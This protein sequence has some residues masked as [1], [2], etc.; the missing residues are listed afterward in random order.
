M[1]RPRT[2]RHE[3]IGIIDKR[4]KNIEHTKSGHLEIFTYIQLVNIKLSPFSAH[5]SGFS[6]VSKGST[7]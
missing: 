4:I 2:Y 3:Q 7:N 5:F 1:F 6:Q